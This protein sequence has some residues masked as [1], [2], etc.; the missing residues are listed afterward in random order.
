MEVTQKVWE[1]VAAVLFF[2]FFVACVLQARANRK[3]GRIVNDED[4]R[5]GAGS[6]AETTPLSSTPDAT[7]EWAPERAARIVGN[8]TENTPYFLIL[9]ML[10]AILY[11]SRHPDNVFPSIVL[12]LY[13]VL[14]L[15]H[16]ICYQFGLQPW[17][18]Y[19][20]TFSFFLCLPILSIATLTQL[21][22]LPDLTKA[23]AIGFFILDLKLHGLIILYPVNRLKHHSTNNPDDVKLVK[24]KLQTGSETPE[25]LQRIE[26]CHTNWVENVPYGMIVMLSFVSL[27]P[28]TS[29]GGTDFGSI[30]IALFV[31]SRVFYSVAYLNALQPWRSILYGI[32]QLSVLIMIITTIV[33]VCS[34]DIRNDLA[35]VYA[36]ALLFLHLKMVWL[37]ILTGKRRKDN[38]VAINAEDPKPEGAQI[39]PKKEMPEPVARVMRAHLNDIENIPNFMAAALWYVLHSTG[40]GHKSYGILL[41]ALF[42]GARLVHSI[43]YLLALQPWRSLSWLLGVAC[44]AQIFVANITHD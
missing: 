13:A 33:R 3:A 35:I 32:G 31:F 38:H 1:I 23:A 15:V 8:D 12:I 29:S 22:G 14:R 19:S 10:P 36:F 30:L 11:S 26:R 42:C 6:T 27:N 25:I 2:K 39:T 44:A 18:T 41:I 16:H 5:R 37:G 4:R 9:S 20:Y 43:V 7:D 17:R 34:A 24:G 21:K 40:D 28:P